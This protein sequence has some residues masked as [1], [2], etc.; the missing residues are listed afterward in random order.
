MRILLITYN[1]LQFYNPTSIQARRFFLELAENGH[2]ITVL[3]NKEKNTFKFQHKNI[4]VIEIFSIK[5]KFGFKLA[6][7]LKLREL[8]FMPDW[9]LF[10][11][12]P[13]VWF[14]FLSLKKDRFDFIHTISSPS[15]SHLIPLLWKNKGKTKWVAQFYDPWVDNSYIN[16]RFNFFKKLN[17]RMEKIVA[18]NADLVIHTNSFMVSKW[19]SRYDK[20]NKNLILPLCM[21]NNFEYKIN[22][23]SKSPLK[24]K[25]I[26]AHVGSI[27]EKRNLNSLIAAL[28][29][30]FDTKKIILDDLIIYLV[31]SI[32]MDSILKIESLDFR[33]VFKMVGKV[34]FEESLF[35]MK[36]SSLL[37]LIEEEGE[38]G[39]FFPSKL[40]D[41]LAASKPILGIIPK[42]CVSR[43]ILSENG[44]HCFNHSDIENIA[45]FIVGFP[46]RNE[47][48]INNKISKLNVKNVACVYEEAIKSI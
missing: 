33:N 17:L 48:E 38:E 5:K 26:L 14:K 23:S 47:T 29:I 25:F 41:Y 44:H 32:D 42:Y 45:N 3:T 39:L 6:S 1:F 27:Y 37:L 12:N 40:T 10:F 11:W 2:H 13:F 8:N 34:S 21:E 16:L 43:E 19:E 7:I 36:Q 35:Y 28:Q 24:E 18:D 4:E 9:E 31:G 20:N 30:I 15:S 22:V 46:K